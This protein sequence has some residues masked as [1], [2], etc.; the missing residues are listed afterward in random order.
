M[1]LVFLLFFFQKH[2]HFLLFKVSVVAGALIKRHGNSWQVLVASR[3]E[4]KHLAGL[5]EY[6]DGKKPQ[7]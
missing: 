6:P 1:K 7:F 2:A 3:P 4:G 5:W